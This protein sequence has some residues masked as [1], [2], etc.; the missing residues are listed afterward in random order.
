VR[1]IGPGVIV[2]SCVSSVIAVQY[3]I[4]GRP[5][6]D[7]TVDPLRRDVSWVL[8]GGAS[9]NAG[10]RRGQDLL[11]LTHGTTSD[12]WRLEVTDDAGDTVSVR[13]SA[14]FAALR[15]TGP[16]AIA[17]A[18][19]S[20]VAVALLAMHRSVAGAVGLLALSFATLPMAATNEPLLSSVVLAGVPIVGIAWMRSHATLRYQ[21]AFFAAAGGLIATWVAARWWLPEAFAPLDLARMGLTAVLAAGALAIA[22]PWGQW[23]IRTATHDPPR[24]V[25]VAAIAAILAAAVGSLAIGQVPLWLVAVGATALLV[26]YMAVRRPIGAALEELLLGGVRD[27]TAIAATEEERARLAGE[28]HDGPLQTIAAA[29]AELHGQG[30]NTELVELLQDAGA[31]LRAVS[32]AMRPSVLDDLGLGAA[33]AWL[34]EQARIR[35]EAD[36]II[37]SEI[38]DA[39]GVVRT[40]RLPQEVELAAFR[41]V[42]E[43]MANAIRH[44]KASSISIRGSISAGSVSLA[45]ADDGRGIQEAEIRQARRVGRMGLATMRKRAAS[46]GAELLV[47]PGITGGV[48]IQLEWRR[49]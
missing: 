15:A 40:A 46:I 42:Q 20:I 1:A 30:A 12:D 17:A 7:F 31:E 36:V 49:S 35:V 6:Q 48:V 8:P 18:L 23:V 41:I 29:I 45:I 24:A 28:I 43:A 25:D 10:I 2:L 5:A 22:A 11:E 38:N 32:A 21:G 3:A 4:G 27:R 9:W 26:A 13:A 33:I 19:L 37:S 39:T 44:A 16:V 34:V 47:A 14:V